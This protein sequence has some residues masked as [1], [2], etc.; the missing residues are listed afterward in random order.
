MSQGRGGGLLII[1]RYQKGE[2]RKGTPASGAVRQVLLMVPIFS[3]K[4]PPGDGTNRPLF[5]QRAV[6]SIAGSL[7]GASARAA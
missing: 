6:I 7:P 4:S 3:K 2:L 5:A 1:Y